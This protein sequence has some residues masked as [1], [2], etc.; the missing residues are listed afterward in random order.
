MGE[1]VF[2]LER[3]RTSILDDV[4]LLNESSIAPTR[5]V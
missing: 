2:L 4:D 5:P 3:T 1:I